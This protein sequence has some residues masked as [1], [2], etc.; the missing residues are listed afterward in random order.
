M[1][2]GDFPAGKFLRA[3]GTWQPTNL[4][5]QI[6]PHDN[7]VSIVAYGKTIVTIHADGRVELGEGY[8]PDMAAKAFWEHVKFHHP[9]NKSPMPD[10]RDYLDALNK[11]GNP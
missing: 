8:T 3:D 7:L 5:L 6:E 4:N 11:I 1:T 10:S 9:A 2:T